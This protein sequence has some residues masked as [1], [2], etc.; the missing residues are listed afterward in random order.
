MSK[1]RKR[2]EI[3]EKYKWDLTTIYKNDND[4]YND[5]EKAKVDIEKVSN[6]K[7]KFL[8]SASNLLEFL[9]YSKKI[10]RLLNKLYYYAHLNFDSDTLNDDYKKMYNKIRDLFTRYSE[11][12]SFFMPCVLNTDYSILEK[13]FNDEPKLLDYKF[14]IDDI[15]RFKKYTLDEDKERLLSNLSKCL[16]TAEDTY[17]ALTDSDL[18]FGTI[19]DEEGKEVLLN[20]S[21][22][23]TY[24]RSKDRKVRKDAFEK[25]LGRYSDFKNTVASCF[26]SNVE[27]DVTGAKLR[28]YE[29][30]IKASL[31]DDNVDISVYDNLIKTVNDNLNIIYKYYNLKKKVLELDELHLYDTYVPLAKETNSKY[32]FEEAKN[33]VIDA[34]SV[35]GDDYVNNLKKAFDERWIDVYH[36]KGKRTGAYSSGFYDTNPFV[37]LNYEG[38]LDDVSTL[39]H[40][41]GHSMH[42]YYSCKNNPYQYSSYSIFVAEVASTVNELLLAKYLLEKQTNKNDKLYILSHLMELFKSTLYRQTMFAEFEKDMHQK[43]EQQEVLTS[44][45]ISNSYYNLVKKYFGDDVVIDDLIRYEWERIPHFYY[46][47]YVYKYATGLSAACYI[48]DSILNK[49][50]NALSNY[51]KFLSSGGSDYPIEELKIAGVNMNDKKVIESAINMFNDIID[52]FMV[53]YNS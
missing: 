35:L 3:E 9:E 7:D 51:I 4:W 5:Y 14:E 23:S 49:K 25:I 20:E 15:Y 11:L 41:L 39:A 47:F 34:L 44:E 29:S 18:E 33:I 12:S 21:N 22:Y 10:S 45:Y 53:I 30:S 19:I 13:F 42:T 26:S 37:L 43:R 32:T 2:S 38:K 28:G 6:Y 52:E 31:Y 36:N 17:D 46:N 40:E 48:V 50:E 24:I 8:K 27:V 16:S 1:E